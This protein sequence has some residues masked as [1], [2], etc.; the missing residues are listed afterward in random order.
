MALLNTVTFPEASMRLTG[1]SD[2]LALTRTW[3]TQNITPE[4]E[5]LPR[6][7]FKIKPISQTCDSCAMH[8][9]HIQDEE[10][11]AAGATGLL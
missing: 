6:D 2:G 9:I 7:M 10:N 1:I 3:A 5:Q 4:D 11:E 8:K